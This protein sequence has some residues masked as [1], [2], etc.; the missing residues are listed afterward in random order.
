MTYRRAGRRSAT[1][2]LSCCALILFG[3]V[4]DAALRVDISADN[5]R[6]DMLSKLDQN[7]RVADG[8]SASAQFEQLTLTVRAT[9]GAVRGDMWKG[10]ID[11]GTPFSNDGVF[12]E[13]AQGVLELVIAGLSPG[14]HSIAT[15]HNNCSAQST[16]PLDV[17]VNDKLAVKNVKPTQRIENEYDAAHAYVEVDVEA[18]KDVVLSFR[19]HGT[20]SDRRVMLNGVEIDKSDPS[21]RAV[22]P[23]PFHG[24]QH[25][26][27]AKLSW[28]TP[29]AAAKHHVYLGT[30]PAV[31]AAATTSSPEYK[32]ALNTAEFAPG[33]LSNL[34]MYYWRVDLAGADGKITPGE[35]WQF[36]PGH[37]AFPGAEG[38]GRFAI[39][40]RAG[41]VYEVTNLND[42]GPGS[43]RDAVEAEGP[44]TVVF[45]VGGTI[46]LKSKLVIKNPYIT[47]AGQTAPG[48]GICIGGYTFGNLGTHDTIIRY[49][50][51]RVGTESGQT[52][53]GSGFASSDHCI[54]DHCSVTWSLDEAVSSRGARNITLQRC[55]V[56]DALNVAGHRNYRAGTQ[57]GYAGSISGNIGSFHHNLI[58][59]C[60]GRNWSLAGGYAQRADRFAGYLD[61]RNNICFNWGHRTTDGGVRKVNFVGNYYIPGPASTVFHFVIA[62]IENRLP[63]DIQQFYIAD[64][65]MEGRPQYDADNWRNGGVRYEDRDLQAIKLAAP[66]CEPHIT[67]HTAKQAYESVMADVGANH[68]RLDPVDQRIYDD[69]ANRRASTKGSVSGKPG[70]I[71]SEKDAGGF[72]ELKSGPAPEDSDHDGMPDDWERIHKLDPADPSDGAQDSGDGYTHLEK[73]LNGI[74]ARR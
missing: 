30:D 26:P 16:G 65:L 10:G 31:V 27:I 55:L 60:A 21:K 64:N 25:T 19:P 2:V 32:G 18:G 48:D 46:K 73:Y 20:A 4:A 72:P 41:R 17:Y 38:Y 39:G 56:A 58:A 70:L 14:R 47:V 36:R 68:P 62:R 61:I 54:M 9:R 44:R 34:N 13:D 71:D 40:G 43:L 53:D 66:F 35:V 74:V 42:G 45:R 11:T 3:S 37:L 1:A 7:W 15:F 69:V 51:I 50:R 22:K 52:M 29:K 12:A 8:P 33:K 6:R 59:N 63:D 57:H 24:D 49:V 67:V 5:D 28:T 23:V